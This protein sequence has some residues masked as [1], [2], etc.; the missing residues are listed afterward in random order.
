MR[1]QSASQLTQQVAVAARSESS[2]DSEP[3]VTQPC[4]PEPQPACASA[5]FA[6]QRAPASS[7]AQPS[8]Q[9]LAHVHA[10]EPQED[11]TSL[12]TAV[13]QV[14]AEATQ[15]SERTEDGDSSP[16]LMDTQT[17]AVDNT[18]T[19]DACEPDASPSHAYTQQHAEASTEACA[20]RWSSLKVK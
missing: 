3:L 20:R 12:M 19:Q 13:S 15:G 16:N 11:S 5:S 4:T 18:Q 1:V 10:C 17:Q 6:L 14:R 7:Q 2:K 8:T 9:D